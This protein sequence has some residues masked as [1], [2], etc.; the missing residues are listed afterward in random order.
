MI[1]SM[2]ESE[3]VV[4]NAGIAPS[5]PFLM[6]L[7]MKSSLRAVFISCGPF[8]ATRPLSVWHQPQVAAKSCGTSS[9]DDGAA[10]DGG[11]A[12]C[13]ASPK[14]DERAISAPANS[15]SHTPLL[16]G[17]TNSRSG[18]E[19]GRGGRRRAP[20]LSHFLLQAVHHEQALIARHA[21][22]RLAEQLRVPVAD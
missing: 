9:L 7:R 16:T 13:C 20:P 21:L 19:K 12:V 1:R 5:L 4:P 18:L 15:G 3:K 11:A 14:S 8:P 17:G 22:E 10:A 6:R 2:S